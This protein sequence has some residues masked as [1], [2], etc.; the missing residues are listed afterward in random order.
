MQEPGGQ[1]G[2]QDYQG[3]PGAKDNEA[4]AQGHVRRAAREQGCNAEPSFDKLQSGMPDTKEGATSTSG[5]RGDGRHEEECQASLDAAQPQCSRHWGLPPESAPGK[6]QEVVQ[7]CYSC[8][9]HQQPEDEAHEAHVNTIAPAA[10]SLQ[11]GGLSDDVHSASKSQDYLAKCCTLMLFTASRAA[12]PNR[13][14]AL[15]VPLDCGLEK[16]VLVTTYCSPA[17]AASFASC[18]QRQCCI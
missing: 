18:L 8:R 6:Q 7:Q 13:A 4:H 15:L 17:S 11:L 3:Q 10:L 9:H 14:H 5:G 2:G 1:Q 12:G 16:P